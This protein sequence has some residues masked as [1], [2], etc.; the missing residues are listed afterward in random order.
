MKKDINPIK[1][2]KKN[3]EIKMEGEKAFEKL[4]ELLSEEDLER[5]KKSSKEFRR[6]FEFK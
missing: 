2:L 1:Q 3:T 4:V 5:I 6:N